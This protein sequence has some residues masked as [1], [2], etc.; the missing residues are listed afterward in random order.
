MQTTAALT[1]LGYKIRL[2]T[3]RM[4]EQ[5]REV[6]SYGDM[7]AGFETPGRKSLDEILHEVEDKED[8]K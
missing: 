2:D 5:W 8:K 1:V 6:G 7:Y 3:E 4:R